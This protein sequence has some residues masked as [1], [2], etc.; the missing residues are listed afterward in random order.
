[1][2]ITPPT[3]F[4]KAENTFNNMTTGFSSQNLQFQ[5]SQSYGASNVPQNT[6]APGLDLFNMPPQ[7]T[8]VSIL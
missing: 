2:A 8:L 7:P 5:H 1:M 3:E 6:A 4:P